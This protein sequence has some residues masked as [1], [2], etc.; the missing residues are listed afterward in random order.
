MSGTKDNVKALHEAGLHY[1]VHGKRPARGNWEAE[2]AAGGFVPVPGRDGASEVQVKTVDIPPEG[3]D[4]WPERALLCRSVGRREKEGAIF[5]KAEDRL[6]AD[7]ERLSRRV[8]KKRMDTAALLDQAVGRLRER[9]P[10]VAR[11]YDI[12]TIAADGK[13]SLA[14]TRL[15]D[16]AGA[17]EDLL[18][19]YVLRTD[20]SDI[21][22]ERFWRLYMTLRPPRTVSVRSSAS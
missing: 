9:H 20:R 2:F 18:G 5:S 21:E 6:A 8:G 19:C 10:R 17:A 16:S 14:W 3:A 7:L 12:S 22:G 11:F 13:L 4:G 15:A 1:L